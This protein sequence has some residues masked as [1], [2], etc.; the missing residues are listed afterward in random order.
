MEVALGRCA[1]TEVDGS[2]VLAATVGIT[3]HCETYPGGLRDLRR[4]RGRNSMEVVLL[5]TKVLRLMLFG[6][7]ETYFN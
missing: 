5:G 6:E 3:F 1:F 4:E 2:T 7:V